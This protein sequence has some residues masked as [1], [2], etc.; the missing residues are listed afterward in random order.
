LDTEAR[1]ELDSGERRELNT[2]GRKELDTEGRRKLDTEGRRELDQVDRLL[3]E[4][5]DS[6]NS[7]KVLLE[8][9]ET[10]VH[11][12]KLIS[13]VLWHMEPAL[14]IEDHS[15]DRGQYRLP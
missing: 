12:R 9:A 5:N 8:Q 13:C 6:M 3:K 4:A 2:E 7:V 14:K 15:V 1:R 11:K 10:E